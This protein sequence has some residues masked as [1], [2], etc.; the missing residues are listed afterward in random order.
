M[1]TQWL[2]G[3]FVRD[4]RGLRRALEVY[5]D[6]ADIWRTPPGISN[7]GGTLA[8]H[9][10]GNIRTFIGAV[11][12][13]SGY[14]RDREA[15]FARRNVP[16]AEL[17]ALVDEAIEAVKTYMPKVTE[18]DLEKP[19]PVAVAGYTITTGDFLLHLVSHLGYHLGQVDYHRR[20]VTGSTTTIGALPTAELSTARKAE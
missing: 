10:V 15:E 18:A 19:Y 6:E 13:H 11:L 20:I 14:V 7:A 2:R 5:P 16:R 17:L 9:L 4:L 3:V 8:L 1:T 12:G